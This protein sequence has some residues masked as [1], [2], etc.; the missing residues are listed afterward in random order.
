MICILFHS[1]TTD[2]ASGTDIKE[3]NTDT[4]RMG[5]SLGENVS[6]PTSETQVVGLLLQPTEVIHRRS[7]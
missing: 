7:I 2:A 3:E 4:E 5:L 1:E 6:L